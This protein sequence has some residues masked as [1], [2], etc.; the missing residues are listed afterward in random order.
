MVRL[1]CACPFKEQCHVFINLGRDFRVIAKD[2][3]GFDVQTH[4]LVRESGPCMFQEIQPCAK[5]QYDPSIKPQ[6]CPDR[7]S[8][9]EDGWVVTDMCICCTDGSC[10]AL[11]LTN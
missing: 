3:W 6:L 11:K 10:L 4:P 2:R 8:V 1:A 9:D 5:A 7:N